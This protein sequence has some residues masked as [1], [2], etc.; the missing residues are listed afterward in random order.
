MRPSLIRK[1]I[2]AIRRLLPGPSPTPLR[3]TKIV[4][5]LPSKHKAAPKQ[6]G[7]TPTRSMPKSSGPVNQF[8]GLGIA[9]LLLEQIDL[10]GFHTPTPIQ[11]KTIPIA[12]EGNDIVGIAQ[13]GTGKTLA[14]GI[15]LI[16]RLSNQPGKAL[17]LAPTRELALQIEE[18][19]RPFTKALSMRSAVL[20]GGASMQ[21]QISALRRHPRILIATPGR[22][23]DIMERGEV[24]LDDT[25]LLVLDEADRMLD[26]GFM[27]QISRILRR[28]PRQRQTM[29]FSATMPPDIVDIAASHM[30]MPVR[31]E[32]APSGTAAESVTQ[33]LFVVRN[34]HKAMLLERL[35]SEYSG[36]VLLFTRTRHGAERVTR[37]L[38][39]TGH[40]VAEIHSDRSLGQRRDA[41]DGFK[42]GKYRILVATDIAARGI[43]VTGIELVLN[44][45]LPEDPENYVHR[46]GRT[47]RAGREGHAISLAT[48]GQKDEVRNI[49]RLIRTSILISAH[50]D[51]PAA[52]FSVYDSFHPAVRSILSA[53][54]GLSAATT[55][56]TIP[57]KA[58]AE[59][60]RQAHASRRSSR[61]RR[62]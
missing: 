1:T 14:F 42:S 31:T 43:D 39:R 33:E 9:P 37:S 7:R 53:S 16:Q 36:S 32:I 21:N 17:I 24:R 25:T 48:P 58:E 11:H 34:E 47:G 59:W 19:L 12:I 13:T 3:E 56:K 30:Q 44:Y 6:T 22:L 4:K 27:P 38:R 41:L 45:D 28:V 52:E 50:P 55:P 57:V 8:Y 26:M 29:L 5:I 61:G 54:P 23:I 35:L 60:G 46:I 62:R 18:A 51:I 40:H 49:E 10:L 20:I 2:A 15:P